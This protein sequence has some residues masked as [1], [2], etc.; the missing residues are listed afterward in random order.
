[1]TNCAFSSMNIRQLKGELP[2]WYTLRHL[3]KPHMAAGGR[4]CAVAI[5]D[6]RDG[7]SVKRKGILPWH[8]LFLFSPAYL[9]SSGRLR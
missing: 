7:L 9:K 2:L 4:K 5:L 1:M 6:A 8:G 3:W